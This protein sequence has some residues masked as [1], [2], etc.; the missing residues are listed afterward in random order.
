LS[1]R[2][3]KLPISDEDIVS[4]VQLLGEVA[5]SMLALPERRRLLMERLVRLV[6]AETWMW[7]CSRHDGQMANAV[8]WFFLDGGWNNDEER[9]AVWHANTQSEVLAAVGKEVD[10]KRH[11]TFTWDENHAGWGDGSIQRKFIYPIGFEHF[12]FSMYPLSTVTFSGIGVHRRIGR[13]PFTARQRAITHLIISQIDWLHR[14]GTDVE[15]NDDVLLTITAR[16]REILVH[17]LGGDRRKEVARKL[18]LSEHTVNDYIKDLYRRLK[19]SSNTQLLAKFL[20][21]GLPRFGNT[22]NSDP[23]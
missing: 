7:V 21:S 2:S 3:R 12:L 11:S 17:L 6:D 5:G 8:P 20:P 9:T 10:P 1:K 18:R 16:Q 15:A 14:A 22:R 4:I 19:V 13:E 23:P